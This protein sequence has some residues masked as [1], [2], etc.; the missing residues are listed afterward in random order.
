MERTRDEVA[1]NIQKVAEPWKV[2]KCWWW[3][4]G[5]FWRRT[6]VWRWEPQEWPTPLRWGTVV[7]GSV[8]RRSEKLV[9]LVCPIVGD[10]LRGLSQSEERNWGCVEVSLCVDALLIPI[11]CELT[12]VLSVNCP[13]WESLPAGRKQGVKFKDI[14]LQG[15]AA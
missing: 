6:Q 4:G 14:W 13:W 10:F 3:W 1:R 5:R 9:R 7:A 15:C 8:I 12:K 11:W 2:C